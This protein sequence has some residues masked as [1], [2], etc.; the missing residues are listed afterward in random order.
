MYQ[1]EK[2]SLFL[3]ALFLVSF[4]LHCLLVPISIPDAVVFDETYFGNFINNYIN[5]EFFFDIHPPLAKLIQYYV[6]KSFIK[7][8]GSFN[9]SVTNGN[10]KNVSLYLNSSNSQINFNF[11]SKIRFVSAYLCSFVAPLISITLL[12]RKVSL[13]NSILCGLISLFDCMKISQSRLILTDGILYFFVAL[14]IMITSNIE[15]LEKKSIQSNS[16][17]KILFLIIFQSIAAGCAFSTKFTAGGLLIYIGFSHI[18]IL[19]NKYI[20][21]KISKHKNEDYVHEKSKTNIIKFLSHLFLRGIICISIVLSVLLLSFYVHFKILDKSGN[22]D[23]YVGCTDR[24]DPENCIFHSLPFFRKCYVMIRMMLYYNSNVSP[25][26]PHS[27]KWFQWPL[28][29]TLPILVYSKSNREFM[30]FY[31]SPVACLLS[32]IGF[33]FSIYYKKVV[34]FIGYFSSLIGFVYMNRVTFLYHYEIPLV[35]G[36]ISFFTNIDKF[37]KEDQKILQIAIFILSLFVFVIMFPQI[38]CLF[39]PFYKLR[40]AQDETLE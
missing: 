28:G 35:F 20:N 7:Y 37:S 24:N 1:K 25:N 29:L 10:Y 27:S 36:L 14:S 33:I 5:H 40:F 6:A 17:L 2:N 19:Y 12:N 31:I 11:Y 13:K 34:D 8:D 15:G 26:H 32:F 23:E 9:F 3:S 16:S 30:Y 21:P 22:G 39:S 18:L 4:F 38:Y